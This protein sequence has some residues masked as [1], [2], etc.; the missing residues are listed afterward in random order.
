MDT[1]MLLIQGLMLYAIECLKVQLSYYAFW[2]KICN[3][4]MPLLGG[5][6]VVVVMVFSGHFG[7]PLV[8]AL[9]YIWT[10]IGY[11]FFAMEEQGKERVRIFFEMLIV[12][13]SI[14]AISSLLT[15]RITNLDH[16]TLLQ[17]Q[18][19]MITTGM[20][21]LCVYLLCVLMSR[22]Y[23]LDLIKKFWLHHKKVFNALAIFLIVNTF[24]VTNLMREY[25]TEGNL[26]FLVDIMRIGSFISWSIL[27]VSII[28]SHKA[29]SL[30]AREDEKKTGQTEEVNRE[31][32]DEMTKELVEHDVE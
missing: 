25:I 30:D 6:V 15:M 10:A 9:V 7:N 13:V 12:K 17:D 1:A 3:K 14:G 16:K 26:R 19:A 23:I 2:K 29:S 27:V 24:A 21:T 11:A 32:T 20:T 8:R 5:G 22:F 18:D 28:E 31:A 4:I